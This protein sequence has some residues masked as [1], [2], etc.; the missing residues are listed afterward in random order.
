MISVD[1]AK[2]FLKNLEITSLF[3]IEIHKCVY[4]SLIYKRLS[5]SISNNNT[6][7]LWKY[8]ILFFFLIMMLESK[9][10]FWYLIFNPRKSICG[11]TS[12]HKMLISNIKIMEFNQYSDYNGFFYNLEILSEVIYSKLKTNDRMIGIGVRKQ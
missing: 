5:L 1:Y 10:N 11:N 4:E 2:R 9:E 6:N 3:L 8:H 12:K 7:K